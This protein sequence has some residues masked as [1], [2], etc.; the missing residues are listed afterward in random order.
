MSQADSFRATQS[1]RDTV[2]ASARAAKKP[3]LVKPE[4]ILQSASDEWEEF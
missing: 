4:P 2:L 3:A 1:Q